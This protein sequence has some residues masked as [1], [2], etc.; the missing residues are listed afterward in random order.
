MRVN[1]WA[2]FHAIHKALWTGQ[3]NSVFILNDIVGNSY[4]QGH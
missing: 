3:A 1:V 2:G 4:H